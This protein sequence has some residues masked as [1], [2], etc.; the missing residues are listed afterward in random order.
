LK[1]KQKLIKNLLFSSAEKSIPLADQEILQENQSLEN[2]G[3]ET[4]AEGLEGCKDYSVNFCDPRVTCL[5]EE[6]RSKFNTINNK[7]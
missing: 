6:F 2:R 7:F 4:V 3:T 1:F 5:I